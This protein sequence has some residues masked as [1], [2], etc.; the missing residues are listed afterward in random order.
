[1]CVLFHAILGDSVRGRTDTISHVFL[2]TMK[3]SIHS[4]D[5]PNHRYRYQPQPNPSPSFS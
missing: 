1:M 3:I 5:L 2:A 4:K